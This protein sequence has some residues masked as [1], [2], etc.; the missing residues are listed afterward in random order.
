MIYQNGRVAPRC[1]VELAAIGSAQGGL[2]LMPEGTA[3][4]SMEDYAALALRLMARTYV[5]AIYKI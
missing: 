5:G 4:L 1:R 2:N 3:N